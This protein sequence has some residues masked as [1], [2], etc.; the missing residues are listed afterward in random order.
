MSRR[1]NAKRAA[2]RVVDAPK[3]PLH[4]FHTHKVQVIHK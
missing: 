2:K 4:D 3:K 1:K